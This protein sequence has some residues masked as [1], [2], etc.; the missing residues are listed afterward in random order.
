LAKVEIKIVARPTT[1][2]YTRY[3]GKA[4]DTDLPLDWYKDGT[5]SP[6][7]IKLSKTAFEHTQTVDLAPGKH[8]IRYSAASTAEGYYWEAEVFVNGQSLGVQSNLWYAKQYVAEFE[9]KPTLADIMAS[10]TGTFM[11]VMMLVMVISILVS[12]IKRLKFK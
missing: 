9:V 10:F 7:Y 11:S 1:D 4:I 3:H 5:A 12:V 2:I 6:Y 8:T